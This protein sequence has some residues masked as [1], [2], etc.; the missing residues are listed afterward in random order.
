MSRRASNAYS[1]V[2]SALLALACAS[3]PRP[4]VLVAVDAEEKSP[5]VAQARAQAPQAF[6]RA[7]ALKRDAEAAHDAGDPA[8]AQIL[9]E[10][11]L[12]AYQ[13]AVTLAGITRA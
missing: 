7:A 9:G 13:R 6:A 2:A 3:A 5:A 1:L 8:Q 10:Q 12:A 4:Q 11:S